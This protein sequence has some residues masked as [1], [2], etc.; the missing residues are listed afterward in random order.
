MTDIRK[1]IE[2]MDK[3]ALA[4]QKPSSKVRITEGEEKI[5][6]RDFVG[7]PYIRENDI[8]ESPDLTDLERNKALAHAPN[9][10]GDKKGIWMNHYRR[11]K[12]MQKGDRE[13]RHYA[14]QMTR[15]EPS[16]RQKPSVFDNIDFNESEEQVAEALKTALEDYVS[17]DKYDPD[18]LY[19]KKSQKPAA[20][21]K[22]PKVKKEVDPLTLAESEEFDA[23]WKQHVPDSG[24]ANSKY[25]EAV[26]AVGRLEYELM[27]NGN[28]NMWDEVPDPFL[29]SG[30]NEDEYDVED[31][32]YEYG[33]DYTTDI[34]R[35]ELNPFYEDLIRKLYAYIIACPAPTSKRKLAGQ[36]ISRI[37]IQP[38][39]FHT[40][41]RRQVISAAAT[42]FDALKKFLI[43]YKP[44][45][46]ES[47]DNWQPKNKYKD[48]PNYNSRYEGGAPEG[49]L[50]C[51]DLIAARDKEEDERDEYLR[52]RYKEILARPIGED[53]TEK[54]MFLPIGQFNKTDDENQPELYLKTKEGT[55][56]TG[57]WD[58]S[59]GYFFMIRLV[60]GDHPA[61]NELPGRMYNQPVEFAYKTPEAKA[62]K[63]RMSESASHKTNVDEMKGWAERNLA[64]KGKDYV[65]RWSDFEHVPSMEDRLIIAETYFTKNQNLAETNEPAEKEYFLSLQDLSDNP[66]AENKYICAVLGLVNGKI[67]RMQPLKAITFIEETSEGYRVKDDQG[68]TATYPLVQ[69]RPNMEVATL[70][71]SSKEKYNKFNTALLLKFEYTLKNQVTEDRVDL[72]KKPRK[73]TLRHDIQ[74]QRK[75]YDKKN[76][77]V[78]PK[79]Q[80]IG[81]AKITK[82]VSDGVRKTTFSL[83]AIEKRVGEIYIGPGSASGNNQPLIKYIIE[84]GAPFEEYGYILSEKILSLS[85]K[86]NIV[87]ESIETNEVANYIF[88]QF[89]TFS[90]GN[91]IKVGDRLCFLELT[92]HD[93][94]NKID[95]YLDGSL[96]YN[97]VAQVSNKHVTFES[98]ESYPKKRVTHATFWNQMVFFHNKQDA[99]KCLTYMSLLAGKKD[100]TTLT[101]SVKDNQSGIVEA[102]LTAGDKF[103]QALEKTQGGKREK[104][105]S[106][107][108][109]LN[110]V[111]SKL[112][113][114]KDQQSKSKVEEDNI[115]P[116][117][118]VTPG[119]QQ[120]NINQQNAVNKPVP[121]QPQ[122]PAQQAPAPT[123]VPTVPTTPGQQ[124]APVAGAAGGA[125]VALPAGT[126][127]PSAGTAANITTTPI[128][129][130][131]AG[132]QQL[133]QP[134]AAVAAKKAASALANIK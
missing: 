56:Y 26:R 97:I 57:E 41:T 69:Q 17:N 58:P 38:A 20:D 51:K 44:V 36:T 99:Q 30:D 4:E 128:Q 39:E 76:P 82:R 115:V 96:R 31:D 52:G 21:K 83:E 85:K 84:S 124:P 22:K 98:G 93:F 40:D 110:D 106:I 111:Q 125:P 3:I 5:S 68:M 34:E 121:G 120:Q 19:P 23:L 70:F 103:N 71:F 101:I 77:P 59:S 86:D 2:S 55:I 122:T 29:W 61:H 116:V 25:G 15:T 126:P 113:Q 75:E 72:K 102:K 133:A 87:V 74:Q 47:I 127:P 108:K 107:M 49:K 132:L 1:L 42:D 73:G 131:A 100:N 81:N 130:L 118:P 89:D 12:S 27:N 78:K 123:G 88:D 43:K 62:V 129:T 95:I 33:P 109:K 46:K 24:E 50:Y 66:I 45:T 105:D 32:E 9:D 117:A 91:S 60:S 53:S 8:E 79:N 114:I 104:I 63:D 28:T 94:G 67:L 10:G 14:D 92:V 13:A 35:L 37:M 54:S 119:Q 65:Y 90:T 48:N 80:M 112:S 16:L 18:T 11:A 7:E 6:E 134:G 64:N